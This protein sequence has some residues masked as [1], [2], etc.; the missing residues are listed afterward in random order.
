PARA[1]A[2]T[3]VKEDDSQDARVGVGYKLLSIGV[4]V[5]SLADY[6]HLQSHTKPIAAT[7]VLGNDLMGFQ[8]ERKR[9]VTYQS[10]GGSPVV[11]HEF[12]VNVK[13]EKPSIFTCGRHKNVV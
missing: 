1:A 4:N 10:L 9:G 7:V 3:R 5:I 11:K 2:L 13:P 6:S 8:L 12:V